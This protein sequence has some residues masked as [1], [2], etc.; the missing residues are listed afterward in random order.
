MYDDLEYCD[1]TEDDLDGMYDDLEY[2]N[3]TRMTLRVCNMT[4]NSV[5]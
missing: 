5:T 3:F 4:L 1:L 2:F